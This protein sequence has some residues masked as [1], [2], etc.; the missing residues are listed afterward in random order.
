M[1]LFFGGLLSSQNLCEITGHH[2][3]QLAKK[4][5]LSSAV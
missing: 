1:A 3:M 4:T 5:G 2:E